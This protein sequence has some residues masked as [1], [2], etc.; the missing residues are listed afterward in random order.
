M[1][2]K[3]LLPFCASMGCIL[4]AAPNHS[5]FREDQ[6][7]FPRVRTAR[8]E[9]DG[10]L[11]QT[12]KQKGL[13]YPP[14]TILLRAFKKEASLELWVEDS[15]GR[16]YALAKTYSICETSGKLG[17][18]R[19]FGDQQVPEGYYE[20]D[21]FNPQSNFYLSLH[22]NYP[23]ASDRILGSRTNPGGDIFLH[24][25]CITIGCLP[26]RDD[27]IKEVY[28]LAVLARSSGQTHLPIQIFPARLNDHELDTLVSSHRT[29][30]Q[31]VEFWTNLKKGFDY[32]EN[33]HR[34]A[35][36]RIERGGKYVFSGE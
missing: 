35:A 13:Q 7:R 2:S 31:L 8:S 21:W 36:V 29:E 27:G 17:P 25:D 9:K 30:P 11:R 6:L 34:P 28:W 20:L 14:R 3:F 5:S 24:G 23:N 26:I 1:R 10:T 22:V 16:S 15:P 33:H 19:V 18:K 32:F 4:L 12:F